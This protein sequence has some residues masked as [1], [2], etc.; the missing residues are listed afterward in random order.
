MYDQFGHAA[1]DQSAGGSYQAV[2]LEMVSRDSKVVLEDIRSI[3][4]RKCR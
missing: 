3:I 4:Y 2:D 1:F